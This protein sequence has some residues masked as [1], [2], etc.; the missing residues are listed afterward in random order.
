M[1]LMGMMGE[2]RAYVFGRCRRLEREDS[3]RLAGELIDESIRYLADHPDAGVDELSGHL[4]H[5]KYGFAMWMLIAMQV[6]GPILIN[7]VVPLVI[8]WWQNRQADKTDDQPTD[9]ADPWTPTPPS[10]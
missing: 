4:R 7:V 6:I 10:A 3:R 9:D 2:A 1:A 5:R 8:E